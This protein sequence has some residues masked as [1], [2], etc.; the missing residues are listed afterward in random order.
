[1]TG[2]FGDKGVTKQVIVLEITDTHFVGAYT[3][4]F[5]GK[6]NKLDNIKEVDNPDDWYPISPAEGKYAALE[7]PKDGLGKAEWVC[8]SQIISVPIEAE[9]RFDLIKPW[10]LTIFIDPWI[11]D[12]GPRCVIFCGFIKIKEKLHSK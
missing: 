11:W 9:V 10:R 12:E 4:T 3:S 6:S 1:M 5:E 8:L 7:A 2:I